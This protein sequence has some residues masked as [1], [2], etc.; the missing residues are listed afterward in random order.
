[1]NTASQRDDQGNHPSGTGRSPT[2]ASPTLA[3]EHALLIRE[4]TARAESV[5]C[6]GDA[7][8]WPDRE[9]HELVNYLQL[10][11]LR[12]I[13]EEEWLLFRAARFD[14]ETLDRLRT[15]HLELRLSIDVLTH[16][17]AGQ[18]MP[19]AQLAAVTREL[20]DQVKLHVANEEGA[21]ATAHA[22]MPSTTTLGGQPHEWY[23]V[24][25]GPV[26]DLDKL[27]GEQ[28]ADAV[29]NRLLRLR[30]DEHVELQSSVE[31]GPLWQRVIRAEPGSYRVIPLERGPRRWRVELIRRGDPWTPQPYA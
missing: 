19:P 26:I 16:A 13:V 25:E 9:L 15:E 28:G 14:S 11:L 17:A 7:G 31:P 12:Q 6:E 4:V 3:E 20:L 23:D 5:V 27:P 18:K 30:P 2:T 21:L 22:E 10:E 29:L 1:M 24:T 8:R